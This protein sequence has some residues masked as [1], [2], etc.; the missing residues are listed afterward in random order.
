MKNFQ[1]LNLFQNKNLGR[2]FEYIY[3]ARPYSLINGRCA[4]EYRKK[5][6]SALAKES[7]LKADLVVPVPY[8]GVPAADMLNSQRKNLN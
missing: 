4:Y 2:V 3:F 6:G 7:D 5:L 8:S 1:V